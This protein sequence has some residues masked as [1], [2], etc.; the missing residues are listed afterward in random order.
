MKIKMFYY[1]SNEETSKERNYFIKI[2]FY[3]Y[4][5]DN[6][7]HIF[8]VSLAKKVDIF[9]LWSFD[10][11]FNVFLNYIVSFINLMTHLTSTFSKF[12]SIYTFSIQKN[13]FI[14]DP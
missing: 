2:L 14:V 8:T 11:N 6:K 1:N 4:W 10:I 5:K 7:N 9:I 12:L 3:I 13:S